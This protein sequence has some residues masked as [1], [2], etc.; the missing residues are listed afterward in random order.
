VSHNTVAARMATLGI[1]GV[2]AV[3]INF[4]NH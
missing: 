1:V 2:I 4:Y 3:Y